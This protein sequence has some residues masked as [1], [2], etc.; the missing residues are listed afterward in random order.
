M[1]GK[2]GGMKNPHALLLG[3]QIGTTTMEIS[4]IMPQKTRNKVAI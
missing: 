4:V 2:M 3:V 1:L